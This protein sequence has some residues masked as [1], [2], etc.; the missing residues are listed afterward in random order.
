M[1]TVLMTGATSFTGCHVA[2]ILVDRGFEVIGTLTRPEIAYD[3]PLL[4]A[5][6]GHSAI[7]TWCSEAPFGSDR[8]RT[9]LSE[10]RVDVFVNHGARIEGYRQADFDVARSCEASLRHVDEVMRALVAAGC[11]RVVHTGTFFEPDEP[12]A[13]EPAGSRYGESKGRTWEGI[14][15]AA[16]AAGLAVSKVVIPN[17][18]GPLENPDRLV[19]SFHR[20]WRRGEIPVVRAP[21][22][23]RDQLPVTWLARTYLEECERGG[24]ETFVRR[25]SGFVLRN[26][27]FVRKVCDEI[28]LRSDLAPRFRVEPEPT[29]EPLRRVNR[30]PAPELDDAIACERFWDDYVASLA[31]S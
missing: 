23:V 28:S 21:D 17:P 5:R 24:A 14:R 19:P 1:A 27:D 10:R 26:A 4:R 6:R 18:I 7:P 29:T 22:L 16:L 2:R 13:G 31:T 25:P 11:R 15:D 12:T 9:L 20:M 8:M 30:E 3:T